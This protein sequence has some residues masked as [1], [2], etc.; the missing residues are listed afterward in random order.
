VVLDEGLAINQAVLTIA[1]AF[2]MSAAPTAIGALI[3]AR[4]DLTTSLTETGRA[5][6]AELEAR[7]ATARASER[8]RIAREIHDAV[9]H[10]ATLIAVESAALA[11]TTREQQTKDTAQRVR[12]LAKETL[13][14]MRAALGLLNAP[15]EPA[16][17]YND[18]P[19]LVAQARAAGLPVHF[20]DQTGPLSSP[21]AGR[22]VYRV[23]QE[24]LTNITK[25][26]PGATVHITLTQQSRA[27]RVTVT[28][29]A[30]AT[31]RPLA[32]DHDGTGLHGLSER[33]TLLGGTFTA[34]PTA[35]GGFTVE[36]TLPTGRTKVGQEDST[37]GGGARNPTNA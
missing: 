15:S 26:A 11:A 18:L 6:E 13:A 10:H 4:H 21:A 8:A 35:D 1:F 37:Y 23:V 25:H 16:E 2:F 22:A 9:G 32:K 27:V 20:D 14:E 36:A 19:R 30:P 33:V 24:A 5:R 29:A 7:E 12:A 28:N 3:T 17:N 34:A 31:T